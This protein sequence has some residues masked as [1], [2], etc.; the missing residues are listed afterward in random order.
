M[1]KNFSRELQNN[2]KIVIFVLY[3]GRYALF[4]AGD[5][6]ESNYLRDE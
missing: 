6:V 4:G 1:H 3:F 2:T 5:R